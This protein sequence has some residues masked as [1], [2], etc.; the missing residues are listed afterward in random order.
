VRYADRVVANDGSLADLERRARE[1]ADALWS[2]W[3]S[4]QAPEIPR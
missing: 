4:R 3:R 2:A 1:L